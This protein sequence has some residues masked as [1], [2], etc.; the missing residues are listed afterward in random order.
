M[1]QTKNKKVRMPIDVI[2]IS[3]KNPSC[4]NDNGI[5][6]IIKV[7]KDTTKHFRITSLKKLAI[8]IPIIS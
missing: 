4:K 5:I 2:I 6:V 7:K 8:E 1:L 3:R